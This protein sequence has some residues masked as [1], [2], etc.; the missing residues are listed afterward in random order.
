LA[1]A[2]VPGAG[3][4][5]LL[6]LLL[7][8][9]QIGVA[10]VMIPAVIYVFSTAETLPAILFLAWAVFVSVIDNVLRPLL[11][12]RGVDVPMFVILIGT[13]G[14]MLL[15]GI[16]G[17]FVGAVVLALGYTLFQAWIMAGSSPLSRVET[18]D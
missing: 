16:I 8:V 17:L 11:L 9:V 2:G 15:S 3:L 14:G 12:G 5:A 13:I 4:W 10:P 6:C 7:A 1:V 18:E